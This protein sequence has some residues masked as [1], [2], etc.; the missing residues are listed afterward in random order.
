MAANTAKTVYH[1]SLDIIE[2][3]QKRF[4]FV[5]LLT[6]FMGMQVPV[7]YFIVGGSITAGL[8]LQQTLT[9]TIM[10]FIVGFTIFSL[11]GTMGQQAGVT[12]M[13]VSRPAFGIVGSV[14]P[15]LITFIEL[16]GWDSVHMQLA[17]VLLNVTSHGLFGWGNQAFFSIIVG[18]IIVTLV[19]YGSEVLKK[20][21]Q[22]LVP[23][24]L[25]LVLMALYV[26]VDGHN[27]GMLLHRAGKGTLTPGVGF[28]AMLISALTWVPM[29]ADYTRFGISKKI[30]F[31]AALIGAVPVAVFMNGIGQISAVSLG[32]A[33]PLIAIVHHGTVFGTVAF[34]VIIF[35]TIAT[36][37]LI[38]YSASMSAANVFPAVPVRTISAVIGVI[39]IILAVTVN[40][41]GN[42]LGWLSFQGYLLIP[43]FSVMLVDYFVIHKGF[44]PAQ[45]LFNRS[46]KYMF[47]K[48]FNL[49]GY[50]SW[51]VGAVAFFVFRNSPIGGSLIALAISASAYWILS[52]TVGRGIS[53]AQVSSTGSTN[54]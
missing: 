28:D 12:T 37:A 15:A 30:T 16:S 3:A 6:I 43:L 42:V 11:I 40:L 13:V 14:L 22:F 5:N 49:I 21:E 29:V 4:N 24:V 7:S 2:P 27:F 10:A 35:A 41:L 23:A 52:V 1:D 51:V 48:G 53:Q 32:N 54:A 34:F 26:A 25:L 38:L 50:G 20:M 44:Y 8:T 46:G 9:V 18:G 33:N 45:E 31:W 39:C 19:A 17:G 36:A 47:F